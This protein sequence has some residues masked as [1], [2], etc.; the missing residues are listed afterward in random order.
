MLPEVFNFDACRPPNEVCSPTAYTMHP[1]STSHGGSDPNTTNG[2]NKAVAGSL[3][4]DNGESD[5]P[6]RR[7]PLITISLAHCMSTKM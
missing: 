1:M 4:A 2:R 6:W 7:A 3:A 5:R